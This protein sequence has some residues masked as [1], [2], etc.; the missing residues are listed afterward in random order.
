MQPADV[1]NLYH[2][3]P[4]EQFGAEQGAG[5]RTKPGIQQG[6][7]SRFCCDAVSWYLLLREAFPG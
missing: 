5:R 2:I 6:A 3:L 4:T 1:P 7:M